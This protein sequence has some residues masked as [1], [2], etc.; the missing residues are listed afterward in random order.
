MFTSIMWWMQ[1]VQVLIAFYVTFVPFYFFRGIDT[2]Y[3]F[4]KFMGY[5]HMTLTILLF[6][7]F[8]ILSVGWYIAAR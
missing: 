2:P 1:C 6:Q 7:G 8:P 4:N 3:C 5:S